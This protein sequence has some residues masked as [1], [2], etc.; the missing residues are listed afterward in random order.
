MGS[1]DKTEKKGRLRVHTVLAHSYVFYLVAFLIGLFLDFIFPL[2]VLKGFVKVPIGIAFII[3]GSLLIFWAQ[4]ASRHFSKE[5]L[6]KKN[7]SKGPYEFTRDPTNWGVFFLMLGFG[8][9]ADASFIIIFTIISFIFSKVVFL[10]KQ[11]SILANKYGDPYLEYKKS[12]K[13]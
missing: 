2:N 1:K 9:M 13:F 5:N 3:F 10:K 11:E 8:I 12:V 6:T 4:R 7:F